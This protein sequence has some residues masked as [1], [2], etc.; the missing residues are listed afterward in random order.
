MG[1]KSIFGGNN[2]WQYLFIGNALPLVQLLTLWSFP[3]SPKWLVQMGRDS[4]ARKALQRLRNTSDVRVDMMLMK[5][6]VLHEQNAFHSP[7]V[8]PHRKKKGTNQGTEPLLNEQIENNQIINVNT[9]TSV[10]TRAQSVNNGPFGMTLEMWKAVKW[11]TG[12]AIVLMLMQQLSGI[13][14]VFYYSSTI[15]NNAGMTW[16]TQSFLK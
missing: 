4:D 3:E 14:A 16:L 15:L 5:G 10:N 1:Y 9:T 11:A 12:I 7:H 8:S 2:T 6:G 13:N